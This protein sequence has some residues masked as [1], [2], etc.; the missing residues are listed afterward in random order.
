MATPVPAAGLRGHRGRPA[1]RLRFARPNGPGRLDRRR[2]HP[3]RLGELPHGTGGSSRGAG[4]RNYW[5]VE[6]TVFRHPVGTPAAV[7]VAAPRDPR[8]GS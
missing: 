8:A 4:E 6:C 1:V 5:P 3:V 2:V 7:A